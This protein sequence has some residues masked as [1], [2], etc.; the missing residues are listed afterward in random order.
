MEAKIAELKLFLSGIKNDSSKR[1]LAELD[2]WK[3]DKIK[4]KSLFEKAA[5][6]VWLSGYSVLFSCILRLL[7]LKSDHF[8]DEQHLQIAKYIEYFHKNL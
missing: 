5:N 2:L 8:S 7:G 1:L 4:A 3:D 6:I